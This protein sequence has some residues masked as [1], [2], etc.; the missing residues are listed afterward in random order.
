MKRII[1]QLI[2]FTIACLS[3]FAQPKPPL[4]P[5]AGSLPAVRDTCANFWTLAPAENGLRKLLVLPAQDATKWI[6]PN[7]LGAAPARWESIAA[8]ELG[9]IWLTQNKGQNK[10]LFDPRKPQSGAVEAAYSPTTVATQQQWEIVARMPASNHDLTAA[11]LQNKFYVAGGLTAEWGFPTRSHPFD[12]LWELDPKNWQWRVAGKFGR[13]RIYC[14]TATFDNKIW[15]V[16][17]D[18]IKSDGTRHAV[19]TVQLFNPRTKNI[20]AGIPNTIAPMPTMNNS[21]RAFSGS[22]EPILKNAPLFSAYCNLNVS[23][24][25]D[26]TSFR[27]RYS[28]ATAF[29]A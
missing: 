26:K 17:G 23:R 1:A 11:V 9:F 2:L 24:A 12:E 21:P 25:N 8:N 18:V 5:P 6:E 14:A 4:A 29:V 27:G 22:E 7:I 20:S 15:I 16:G 13:G 19:T 10:F 3:V 28:F